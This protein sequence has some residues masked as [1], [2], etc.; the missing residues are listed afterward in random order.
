MLGHF[1]NAMPMRRDTMGDFVRFSGRQVEVLLHPN[2]TSRILHTELI[3]EMNGYMHANL[4]R[5]PGEENG[6]S[7]LGA[8]RAYSRWIDAAVTPPPGAPPAI[9]DRRADALTGS[10]FVA[11][12]AGLSREARE[13]AIL[14][15]LLAGN[16]P[17][18]LRILRSVHSTAVRA[19]GTVDS[20]RSRSCRTTSRSGRTPISCACR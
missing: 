19:D 11:S 9:P 12:I 16:V 3:G 6:P 20:V 2:P 4:S 15:E 14:R 10:A 13:S 1:E 18:F 5:R 7:V 17:A 8:L